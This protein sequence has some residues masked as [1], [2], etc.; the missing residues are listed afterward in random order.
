MQRVLMIVVLVLPLTSCQGPLFV[1]PLIGCY[2]PMARGSIQPELNI[3]GRGGRLEPP[4]MDVPGE[5]HE[6]LPTSPP[7]PPSELR[8]Y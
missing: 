1:G 3:G 2:G 6:E 8:V 4:P 7:T 5:T